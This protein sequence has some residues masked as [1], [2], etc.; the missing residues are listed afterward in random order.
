MVGR[1][2][3]AG[4]GGHGDSILIC[5]STQIAKFKA[6]INSPMDKAVSNLHGNNGANMRGFVLGAIALQMASTR[7]SLRLLIESSLLFVQAEW[8]HYIL[9]VCLVQVSF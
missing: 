4:F 2:G 8:Y 6:L 5:N 3:R 1:A 7:K 9:S